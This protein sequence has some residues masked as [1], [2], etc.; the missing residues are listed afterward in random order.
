MSTTHA[1]SKMLTA[2]LAG[3]LVGLPATGWSASTRH[4]RAG[5]KGTAST[6]QFIKS[7]AVGGLAEVELGKLAQDK[8]SN[9]KVKDF[10]KRMVDD[11][12]KANEELQ[13]VASQ[14]NIQM[15]SDL[16]A[17]SKSEYDR[18]SK[19][20]GLAFDRAYMDDMLKDHRTDVAE[21]E[22]ATRSSD[23]DVKQFASQTLPTLKEH[24]Q[25]A[26]QIASSGRHPAH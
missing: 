7:A 17:K 5:T 15:P 9:D 4:H 10:G 26:E 19:L 25:M 6:Q 23:P 3:L 18:L 13:R 1:R 11:H 20:S 8:A 21:F 12:G 14:K 16:D 24:L 22:K 2:A